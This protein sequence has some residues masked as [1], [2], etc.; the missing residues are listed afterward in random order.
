VD[1]QHLGAERQ[2][3]PAA[4]YFPARASRL[5]Q[6]HRRRAGST[7]SI[8]HNA[9]IPIQHESPRDVLRQ[10]RT[11]IV[12]NVPGATPDSLIPDDIAPGNLNGRRYLNGARELHDSTLGRAGGGVGSNELL[13]FVPS[14]TLPSRSDY[15]SLARKV[16][17]GRRSTSKS[18]PFWAPTARGHVSDPR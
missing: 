18:R 6:G 1:S 17:R 13:D 4:D 5:R 12:R 3:L 15:P 9:T 2:D 16:R 8:S 14:V 10:R 11:A 7:R